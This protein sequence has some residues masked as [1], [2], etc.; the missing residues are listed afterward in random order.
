MHVYKKVP[1]IRNGRLPAQ[2]RVLCLNEYTG[3]LEG[4]RAGGPE[5]WGAGGLE[6]RRAGGP[7][8]RRA[9]GPEGRRA[10]GPVGR[11]AQIIYQNRFS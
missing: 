2:V 6:G 3:G 4:R 11:L 1:K 8:G 9:G 7:E 5:G 10:R